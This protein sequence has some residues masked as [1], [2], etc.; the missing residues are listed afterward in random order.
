[1]RLGR[2]V[3]N[4]DAEAWETKREE[5]ILP[6]IYA[7][8][9]QNTDLKEVLLNTGDA[10]LCECAPRNNIWGI[11]MCISNPNHRD[12]AK[13]K[14]KNFQGYLLM[15][16]RDMLRANEVTTILGAV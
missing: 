4:F 1:M 8:F 2:M 3:H 6:G 12:P 15:K 7:K 11:G 16:V 14:G 10:I 5:L 9:S 13:W